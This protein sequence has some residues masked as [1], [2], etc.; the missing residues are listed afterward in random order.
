[1]MDV[2]DHTNHLRELSECMRTNKICANASNASFVGEEIFFFRI[3]Q[4]GSVT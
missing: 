3:F 1:M 4:K 2:E